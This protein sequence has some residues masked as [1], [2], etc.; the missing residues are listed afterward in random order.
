MLTVKIERIDQ[1]EET[2]RF[3]DYIF[4]FSFTFPTFKWTMS[5]YEPSILTKNDWLEFIEHQWK[6]ECG[7]LN[8]CDSNGIVSI[9][10][11]NGKTTFE[12]GRYGMGGGGTMCFEMN[13]ECCQEAFNSIGQFLATVKDKKY[14]ND[15]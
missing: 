13:N 10:T 6:N 15:E 1:S 8:M 4:T 14:F 7:K 9:E 3:S 12:V 11:I 5:C 2:L